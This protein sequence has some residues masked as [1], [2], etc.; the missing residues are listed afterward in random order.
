[1][2]TRKVK[3]ARINTNALQ[4]AKE[5]CDVLLKISPD[6]NVDKLKRN[7]VSIGHTKTEIKRLVT[8]ARMQ[9]QDFSNDLDD[10]YEWC[11]DGDKN[12][13]L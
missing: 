3:D 9:L 4:I 6:L 8:V 10:T 7:Q 5:I 13:D 1:M 11:E 2:A 12:A